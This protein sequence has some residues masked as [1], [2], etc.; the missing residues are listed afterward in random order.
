MVW[1]Q[2][3]WMMSSTKV[4]IIGRPNVGKSTLFNRLIGRSLALV[5]S[6]AG[7]TRDRHYGDVEW[8]GRAFRVIDTGGLIT[9]EDPGLQQAIREQTEDAITE[10]QLILFLIDAR[11]G[12]TSVDHSIAAQLRKAGKSVVL[13]ANKAEAGY[14]TLDV[15]GVYRLGF[16]EPI[17]ISAEHGQGVGDLLDVV[18]E[19]LPRMAAESQAEGGIQVAI[20]GRPNAGKSSLINCI[21]GQPR[22]LVDQ[23]PGTTRDAIDSLLRVNKRMY[24]LVDTAGMRKFRHVNESLEKAAVAMSLRRIQRCDVAVLVLDAAAGVGAQDVRIAAYIERQGKA[25][26]VAL[27]KWDA[28]EKTS[29]TYASFVQTVQEAMPFIAHVPILSVSALTGQRVVKLFPLI[30]T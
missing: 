21:L 13:V 27:N 20:V 29:A 3:S 9:G 28:V 16:G 2:R 8:L 11:E 7:V 10:A 23:T 18:L 19:H 12:A 25:C 26:I 15:M 14:G 4:A 22:L 6:M 5:N 1:C 17:L 24:T 30:D